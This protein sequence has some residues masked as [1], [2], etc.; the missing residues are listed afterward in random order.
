ME[1][2]RGGTRGGG[3]I[4][5][6]KLPNIAFPE[7]KYERHNIFAR[8]QYILLGCALQKCCIYHVSQFG[9]FGQ[10]EKPEVEAIWP[11]VGGKPLSIMLLF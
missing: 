1:L 2:R 9:Q 3:G 11:E 10:S 8:P 6:S 7:S 5:F 4:R